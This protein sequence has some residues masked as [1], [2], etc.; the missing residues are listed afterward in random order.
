MLTTD[1]ADWAVRLRRL[2]EHGMNVSAAER[3]AS[4]KPVLEAYLETGWNFR[5]T[6]IQAAD[7]AIG[8]RGRDTLNAGSMHGGPGRD[9]LFVYDFLDLLQRAHGGPG[10]DRISVD[11]A[12]TPHDA[13]VIDCGDG[14]DRVIY[15]GPIDSADEV[16]DCERVRGSTPE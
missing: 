15:G 7:V 13:D 11:S 4:E 2:R 8:G 10:D 14:F 12:E 16:I 9:Q 5:M 3:H 1:N 6:D